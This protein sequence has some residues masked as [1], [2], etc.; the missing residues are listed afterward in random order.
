MSSRNSEDRALELAVHKCLRDAARLPAFPHVTHAGD[1]LTSEH[2]RWTGGFFVGMLWLAGL[3]REDPRIFETA[4]A[5]ALRLAPRAADRST[6]DMGFLFEPSC[7][8]GYNIMK[9]EKLR[10]L[11]VAAGQSLASRFVAKGRYIPAWDPS[12]GAEYLALAIVDTVMNL[13]ILC[14][15]A[16]ESGEGRLRDIAGQTASTIIAQHIRPD[17]STWHVVDHDP[18]TGE[19]TRRGTHQ[20][21][22]ANSCWSRGQAWTL[23]GFARMAGLH[24]AAEIID[25]ARRTADYFIAQMGTRAVPPWDFDPAAGPG[26]VD[27]AAGAIAASGLLELGRRTG[28]SRYTRAAESMVRGLI[29]ACIDFDHPDLPGLLMHGT[30]DYPRRSG[31]DES[32]IYGDHFFMEALVKLRRPDLWDILGCCPAST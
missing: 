4:R 15:A 18:A 20:G 12:E 3:L 24:P 16:R 9:D 23:Y 22:H 11:A 17:G 30:V 1:W 32:I 19:V 27:S 8:R 13:P 6:H 14:W 31:V 5:W 21:A 25:A 7:V 29:D 2:A 26:P 10:A 28:D